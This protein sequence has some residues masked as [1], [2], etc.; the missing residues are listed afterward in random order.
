MLTCWLELDRGPGGQSNHQTIQVV[1][2]D[3]SDLGR[4]FRARIKKQTVSI[5]TPLP[6][7]TEE[8]KNARFHRQ[9]PPTDCRPIACRSALC[10]L[11]RRD[12]FRCVRSLALGYI[13]HGINLSFAVRA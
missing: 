4:D 5:G 12:L 3:E 1:C 7:P 8:L 6:W 2:I 13:E 11:E 10:P 9:V